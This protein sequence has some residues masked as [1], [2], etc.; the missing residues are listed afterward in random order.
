L[1]FRFTVALLPFGHFAFGVS[2]FMAMVNQFFEL[3]A[4]HTVSPLEQS[5]KPR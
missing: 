1:H 2:T 3:S 5:A 4:K